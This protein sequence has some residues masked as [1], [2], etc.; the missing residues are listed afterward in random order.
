[1]RRR[2]F[3]TLLSGAAAGWPLAARGQ[4]ALPV[5]GFLDP[6]PVSEGEERRRAFRQG[7]PTDSSK[8]KMSWSSIVS[9]ASKWEGCRS[10]W[11]NLFGDGFPSLWQPLVLLR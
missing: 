8:A 3:I 11:T 6:Q 1:M 10:C 5:V 7:R 2:D 4:Q 9:A